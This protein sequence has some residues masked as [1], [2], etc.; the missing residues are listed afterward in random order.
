MRTHVKR[1]NLLALALVVPLQA[2]WAQNAPQGAPQPS[3][4]ATEI[5]SSTST[6]LD[7][8]FNHKAQDGTT[9][10]AGNDVASALADKIKAL[11]ALQTPVLD[12]PETRARF[13]TYLSLKEVPDARITEYFDKM[14]QVSDTLKAGDIFGA[15]KMLYALGDYKDLDAGI[16]RE[17]ANRVEAIW[18]ND[19]NTNTIEIANAKLRDNVET[20]DHNADLIADDLRQEEEDQQQKNKG[21]NS[22]S[23][24]SQNAS[25]SPLISPNADPAAAE[26]EVMPTMGSN[27][28]GK[29]EL[30]AEYLNGLEARAKI[31]LNEM[32]ENRMS[33]QVRIDFSDYIRTLYNTHRYY[34]VILAADFYRALFNTGD[35]PAD[36]TNQA[37]TSAGANAR[38]AVDS[39]NQVGKS[40]GINSAGQLAA[41]NKAGGLLGGDTLGQ[42][43][44]G[45]QPLTI[46]DEVTSALEIN[47]RVSQAI[48]VFK[49]KA[50]LGDIAAASDQLEEAFVAN[51][52][53]P[54]LQGLPREEK[55][56][57]GTFLDK[58]SVLKNQLE[59]RDWE[60]VEGQIDD[61]KKV[62]SDFDSTKP[63]A[64]VNAVKLESRLRLGKAR[65]LAQS[66]HLDEAMD[67]F[68][69]A[70][71]IWPG[72]PDLQTDSSGFFNT[73]DL[74]NQSTAE[75]DRL[76]K[77][78]NYRAIYEKQVAFA[79]AVK[80]DVTR[81]QQ[82]TDA[83]LKVQ[84][85]EMASEKA[86]MLMMSG[87]V[88][89]AWETVELA[90]KDWPDDLKLNKLLA[91]LSERSADF[92]SAIN[93]ARDA[94]AK[95]ELGY[96][97]T[98]YVNAQADYPAS[99]IANDGIDRVSK[100]IL[101]P[102]TPGQSAP[103][104]E[105]PAPSASN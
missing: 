96:S 41:L 103:S 98:W 50:D 12:D 5:D 75:F 36:L 67:A 79:P 89:G 38:S 40:L 20:S 31:K 56:K 58:L 83:L 77:D 84:K 88:D 55:E 82:L 30:T 99:I 70:A 3:N 64:M 63:I 104:P 86:N 66:G 8:L 60:Q 27:L 16:S 26:A 59:A 54:G 13:E 51:E 57:V 19:Q 11:D 72:N 78:G 2:G 94:E 29:M 1:N 105:A 9:A 91:T 62:A 44:Q 6:G 85:A 68:Q 45:T 74:Q 97:L 32:K 95:M 71:E 69:V 73:E 81:T 48:E 102:Q 24:S 14:S 42:T 10:K 47:N 49:Y 15:W 76:I 21:G 46:A 7:Y 61:I 35:Y 4:N 92:V 37:T 90:T 101:S 23:V 39:F 80:G 87:D 25:N 18:N 93:N 65:L 33:D 34:H 100:A 43:G 28:Q 53:H 22:S 17:L 52:F